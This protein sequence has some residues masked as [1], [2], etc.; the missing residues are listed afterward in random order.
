MIVLLSEIIVP[1]RGAPL[2]LGEWV[3]TATVVDHV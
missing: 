1:E 3:S 2:L